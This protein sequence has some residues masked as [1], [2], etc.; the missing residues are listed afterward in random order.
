LIIMHNE[1]NTSWRGWGHYTYTASFQNK[2]LFQLA[3]SETARDKIVTSGGRTT[4]GGSG[5]GL[6]QNDRRTDDNGL[7]GDVFIDGTISGYNMASY[8]LMFRAS[9]GGGYGWAASER[10][11]TRITTTAAETGSGDG[12]LRGHAW[13]GI[14]IDH[15]HSGY[16]QRVGSSGVISYCDGNHYYGTTGSGNYNFADG[17]S[18]AGTGSSCMNGWEHGT[19]AVG[20]AFFVK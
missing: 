16:T 9:S 7:G 10:N 19:L 2:T 8:N 13:A 20:H 15:G 17:G 1:S 4:T 14:G 18:D 12:Q 5:S 11:D 6:T 3:S